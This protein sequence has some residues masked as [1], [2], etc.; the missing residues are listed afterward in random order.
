MPRYARIQAFCVAKFAS[1]LSRTPVEVWYNTSASKR[2]IPATRCRERPD[3]NAGPLD[4]LEPVHITIT[5]GKQ[6]DK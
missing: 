4:L 6:V 1:P 2:D 3:A 5:S